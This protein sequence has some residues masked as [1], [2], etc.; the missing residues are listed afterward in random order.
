MLKNTQCMLRQRFL[1]ARAYFI[2]Q[3]FQLPKIQGLKSFKAKNIAISKA[4][5]RLSKDAKAKL[6]RAASRVRVAPKRKAP[7]GPWRSFVK[8]NY[9][10]VE[11]LPFK[12]R[13]A[14]L[15]K[16]WKGEQ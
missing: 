13:L 11:K 7:L 16:K 9:K 3:M 6:A 5:D 2:R 14:V 10:S 4:W 1:T 15:A 12:K 8:K